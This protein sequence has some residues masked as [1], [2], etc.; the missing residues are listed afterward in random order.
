MKTIIRVSTIE[1]EQMRVENAL[2]KLDWYKEKGYIVVLPKSS[3]AE[4]YEAAKYNLDGIIK[5][6][7]KVENNFL[8]K[9]SEVFGNKLQ[10]EY[11]V[12]LTR[13]GVGGSYHLPNTII[14]NIADEYSGKRNPAE[15]IGH[16]IIHL[17]LEPLIQKYKVGHWQKE[18]LADLIASKMIA[19]YHVQKIPIETKTVEESFNR[20]FPDI[21]KI[22]KSI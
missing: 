19:D 12:R 20:L 16:E 1:E 2:K 7:L 22:I 13:Y 8:E 21:E 10:K 14:L 5:E 17:R 15:S 4:E 6:W 11:L 3:V 18:R 9:L